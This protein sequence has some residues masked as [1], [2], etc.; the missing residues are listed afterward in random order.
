MALISYLFPALL[1]LKLSSTAVA[2]SE[3]DLRILNRIYAETSGHDWRDNNGWNKESDDTQEMCDDYVGVKCNDH[4]RVIS[5]RLDNQGMK[6]TLPTEGD[7][8]IFG[9][10]DLEE[11]LITDSPELE[12]EFTHHFED[13]NKLKNLT[14]RNVGIRSMKDIDY[15][16]S[17]LTKLEIS[18]NRGVLT[19][20]IP[21]AF[22]TYDKNI[23]V[24]WLQKNSLNGTISSNVE[25]LVNLT[26]F[27]V[28]HNMLTGELPTSI[29]SLSQLKVLA[30]GENYLSG[31]I[32][33]I[34]GLSEIE[35]LY[36]SG[37]D[38]TGALGPFDEL[39]YLNT[40]SLQGNR[41]TGKIPET[42]LKLRREAHPEQ[43]MTIKIGQNELTGK[44]PAILGDF[45]KLTIHAEDNKFVGFDDELNC[46]DSSKYGQWNE[47]WVD[48]Y[49]C[50][51]IL[52]PVNTYNEIGRREEYEPCQNC[53]HDEHPV[54]S[55]FL[56]STT[57]NVVMTPAPTFASQTPAP[58]PQ[59]ILEQQKTILM[60]MYS[61]LGGDNWHHKYGWG[62]DEVSICDW[63]GVICGSSGAGITKL[64]LKGN[65][66]SGELPS[67]VFQLEN[68][69]ELNLHDNQHV[70]I[71]D[72]SLDSL[73]SSSRL[74]HLILAK[75]KFLDPQKL[76]N[77]EKLTY[78]D[79]SENAMT[80]SIPES[81]FNLKS[82]IVSL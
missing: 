80:G 29:G 67:T 5:L 7:D 62:D 37:N 58:H 79:I 1:V 75:V 49:G 77:A 12:V 32:P 60:E 25:K 16:P 78:L 45:K 21:E 57:C 64:N 20:K 52:C 35:K 2:T 72:Q 53:F 40:I 76:I 65:N 30:V 69:T 56:G 14:L 43:H 27:D 3:E 26:E 74:T 44:I 42:F 33:D 68:L 54:G 38:F 59:S 24:L 71:T 46:D 66:L 11:L 18:E 55:T 17:T 39:R 9:L 81:L 6:G 34:N 19:G 10:L 41:L 63:Y 47:G 70:E 8:F 51:A 23:E 22:W 73:N 15:A 13:L 4:Q 82:L 31:P 48:V 36:M 50:E 28:H 61:A